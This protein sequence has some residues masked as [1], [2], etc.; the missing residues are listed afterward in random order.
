MPADESYHRFSML[1]RAVRHFAR[2][3]AFD[4]ATRLYRELLD[5]DRGE[6]RYSKLKWRFAAELAKEALVRQKREVAEE[7]IAAAEAGIAPEHLDRNDR[8]LM[9]RVRA[10]LATL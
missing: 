7:I 8:E 2:R 5:M 9:D 6:V 3:G 4:Q 1:E 10:D